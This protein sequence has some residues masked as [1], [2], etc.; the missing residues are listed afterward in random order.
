M[1]WPFTRLPF[2]HLAVMPRPRIARMTVTWL[3]ASPRRSRFRVH[4]ADIAENDTAA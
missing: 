2:F 1:G 3:Q 4:L